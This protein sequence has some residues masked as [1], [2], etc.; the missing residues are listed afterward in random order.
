MKQIIQQ[1]EERRK[2]CSCFTHEES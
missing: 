2:C 1:M